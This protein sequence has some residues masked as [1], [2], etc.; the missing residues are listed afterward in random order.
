MRN[1]SELKGFMFPPNKAT[2]IATPPLVGPNLCNHL[3]AA[4]LGGC[5]N[6][7]EFRTARAARGTTVK[8]IIDIGMTLAT[9]ML[10]YAKV[11]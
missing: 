11:P 4:G 6:F 7:E 3:W 1:I 2:N 5:A 8:Q 9:L 10:R